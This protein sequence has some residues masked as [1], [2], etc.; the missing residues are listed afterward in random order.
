LIILLRR[1]GVTFN[2]TNT[3]AQ[4]GGDAA[5]DVL[6]NFE[7]VTGSAYADV[8]TGDA[9][10][11]MIS[12][13]AGD[14]TLIGDGGATN[15]IVNGS[16]ETAVV[17]DN[18]NQL[19]N[20]VT[21]WT[22]DTGQIQIKGAGYGGQYGDEGTQ[23]ADL[24]AGHGDRFV[25]SGHPDHE[26]TILSAQLRCRRSQRLCHHDTDRQRPTGTAP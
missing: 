9:H 22:A 21:G 20:A 8:L 24:D 26:R 19:F 25:P 3:G 7:N 14:D 12:G 23:F 17:G 10:A 16:F 13:G 15:L 2:L 4:S 6:A 5:G 11:N 1:P 18:S